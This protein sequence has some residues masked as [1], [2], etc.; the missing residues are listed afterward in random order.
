MTAIITYTLC[1]RTRTRYIFSFNSAKCFK[2]TWKGVLCDG[3]F[4]KA[5]F[6]KLSKEKARLE[7]ARTRA[8][9]ETTS[10]NRC[11]KAL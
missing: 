4:V 3:N 8:I 7:V 5:D 9:K 10:L 6:N 2:C 11:I 1:A